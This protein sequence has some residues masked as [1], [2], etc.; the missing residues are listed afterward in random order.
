MYCS[1]DQLRRGNLLA[2]AREPSSHYVK[3]KA[4]VTD[5]IASAVMRQLVSSVPTVRVD[6]NCD[7]FKFLHNDSG[8]AGFKQVVL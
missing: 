4:C 5:W 1:S 8:Q 3:T 7:L 2:P 6:Q